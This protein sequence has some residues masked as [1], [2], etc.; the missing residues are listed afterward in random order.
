MV[1]LDPETARLLRA[2]LDEL[3]ANVPPS[4]VSTKTKVAS[5][6]LEA[7]SHGRSPSVDN[8]KAAGKQALNQTP[9]MWR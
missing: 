3:C 5:K 2:V 4:D 1:T 6:L 9:T 7:V 8:L